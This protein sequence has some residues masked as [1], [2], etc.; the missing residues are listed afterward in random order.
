MTTDTRPPLAAHDP[1]G[2]SQLLARLRTNT[3][4]DIELCMALALACSREDVEVLQ[5]L[6]AGIAMD[7]RR[8]ALVDA[9]LARIGRPRL[10]QS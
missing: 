2:R 9:F 3:S 7:A 1:A 8:R 10:V 4:S 6:S 5:A